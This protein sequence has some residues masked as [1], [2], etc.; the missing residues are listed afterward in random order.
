MSTFEKAVLKRMEVY[1]KRY[2]TVQWCRRGV[3]G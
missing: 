2:T 1:R 3:R